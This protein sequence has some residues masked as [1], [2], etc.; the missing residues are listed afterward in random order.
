[1]MMGF[2][3]FEASHRAQLPQ[4]AGWAGGA[5]LLGALAGSTARLQR[6][7]ARHN[8]ALVAALRRHR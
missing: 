3:R 5:L 4:P 7:P 6:L 2:A 1:L 8:D